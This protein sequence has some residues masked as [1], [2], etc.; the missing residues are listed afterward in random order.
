MNLWDELKKR[1]HDVRILTL[2][3]NR[4]SYRRDA[5]DYIRTV[6][7]PVYPDVRMPTSYRHPF[8]K[9][10]IEWKPDVIHSQCEFF[11][12]EFAKYISKKTGAPI[13][14]TAHTMYDDYVSYLIKGERLGKWVVRVFLRQR[15]KRVRQVIVPS[16]KMKER[17]LSYGVSSPICVLPSGISLEQHKKR[18]SKA[19]RGQRRRAYGL[20]DTHTVLVQ[21]GRLGVEKSIDELLRYFKQSATRNENVRLLIVGDGPDRKRLEKLTLELNIADRVIF[22]GMVQ[23]SEVQNYYQLGDVFVSASTSETQGLTYIEAAANG[24]PLL[25]RRDDCLTDVIMQG[26]NGYQYNDETEFQDCLERILSDP[27]WLVSAGRYSEQVANTFDKRTFGEAV[28]RVYES[29]VAH[30]DAPRSASLIR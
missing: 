8:I 22:T 21:L 2:S 5:V 17:L 25:C 28:E 24:L 14:N 23:P 20:E 9:E 13:V 7:F 18:L 27:A 11:S 1:G 10:I 3:E 26:E 4:H 12:F 29:M 16:R 19:E 30:D 15:L 6:S